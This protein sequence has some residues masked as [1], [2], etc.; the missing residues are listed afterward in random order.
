LKAA[1]DA[2]VLDTT[3]LDIEA[4]FKS[5]RAIVEAHVVQAKQPH[6]FSN[7]PE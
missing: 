3:K 7:C 6:S 5:A 1:E 4:V 2:V